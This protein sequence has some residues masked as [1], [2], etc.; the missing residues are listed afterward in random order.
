[1]RRDLPSSLVWT[2][3]PAVMIPIMRDVLRELANTS[4]FDCLHDL[5]RRM[6]LPKF[7]RGLLQPGGHDLDAIARTEP[8]LADFCS[9]ARERDGLWFEWIVAA[10]LAHYGAAVTPSLVTRSKHAALDLVTS[11]GT[12]ADPTL[13][14]WSC[15]ISGGAGPGRLSSVRSVADKLVGRQRAAVL[16][17]PRWQPKEGVALRIGE[18]S[19]VWAIPRLGFI[20]DA[21]GLRNSLRIKRLLSGTDTSWR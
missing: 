17:V 20:V 11:I 4:D 14:Y 10:C 5:R 15:R 19:G 18:A 12:A 16:V 1:M 3:A 21:R 9:A 6:A 2:S 8:Q 13:A 7:A